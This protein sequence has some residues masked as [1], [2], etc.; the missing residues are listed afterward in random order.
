MCQT[1][2]ESWFG[3]PRSYLRQLSKT[4]GFLL[5][6]SRCHLAVYTSVSE[7]K[8]ESVGSSQR[9][10]SKSATA[11]SLGFARLTV[12]SII[13]NRILEYYLLHL[14]FFQKRAQE[15]FFH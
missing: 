7:A 12:I 6:P 5:E 13:S 11:L 1:F 10:G 4:D 14:D 9:P 2:E 8:A 15:T 3:L